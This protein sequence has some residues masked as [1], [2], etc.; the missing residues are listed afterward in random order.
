MNLLADWVLEQPECVL[1]SSLW[2]N[3]FPLSVRWQ[4]TQIVFM[5]IWKR[6]LGSKQV[7]HLIAVTFIPTDDNGN[8]KT[9][10]APSLSF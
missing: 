9:I 2:P 3:L 8:N 10:Q 5:S 7:S 4:T 6:R 1:A